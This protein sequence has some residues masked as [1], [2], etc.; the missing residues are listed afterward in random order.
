MGPR[1]WVEQVRP[2]VPGLKMVAIV[3]AVLQ[4][5]V[6]PY[7]ASGQL[8]AL[9]STVRD[10]TAYVSSVSGWSPAVAGREPS[11]AAM[12]LGMI[13][14]MAFIAQALAGRLLGPAAAGGAEER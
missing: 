9:L 1:S 8:A 10:D 3:P 4:P 6:E 14:A 5:E 7:R 13:A 11:A 12:L 2:R